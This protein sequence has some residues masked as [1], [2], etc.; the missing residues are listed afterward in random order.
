MQCRPEQNVNTQAAV[1]IPRAPYQYGY[2]PAAR[3]STR[4]VQ[5]KEDRNKANCET[6]W[7][8]RN[9]RSLCRK[10]LSKLGGSL[11]RILRT[12]AVP[13]W[14]PYNK[15]QMTGRPVA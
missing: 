1:R 2:L 8:H 13:P 4:I 6:T 14:S 15:I 9:S 5:R 7:R 10:R 11:A 12:A 3:T